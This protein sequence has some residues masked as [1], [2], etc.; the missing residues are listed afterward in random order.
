MS[1]HPHENWKAVLSVV[2]LLLLG[3]VLVDAL[4]KKND[5]LSLETALAIAQKRIDANEA[6]RNPEGKKW[7]SPK[8][9]SHIFDSYDGAWDFY[10]VS[11]GCEYAIGVRADGSTDMTGIRG[12]ENGGRLLLPN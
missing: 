12:C 3:M 11:A 4:S 1:V 8:L 9:V 5:A 6:R 2:S 10:F 7:A